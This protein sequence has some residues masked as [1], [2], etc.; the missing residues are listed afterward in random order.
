MQ[1]KYFSEIFKSVET[2]F[3]CTNKMQNATYGWFSTGGVCILGGGGHMHF[4]F[5]AFK[6]VTFQTVQKDTRC[7]P[8]ALLPGP[9]PIPRG[10][11][12]VPQHL[13]TDEGDEGT[14]VNNEKGIFLS[15]GIIFVVQSLSHVLRPLG[16]GGSTPGLA[17]LSFTISQRLLKLK[18]I[19]SVMLSNHV[20]LGCP[21]LIL[22]SIF[23]SIRVFSKELALCIR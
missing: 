10:V 2:T 12:W 9:S 5:A 18:S 11:H 14:Q 3:S 6:R 17:S 16:L 19:E 20:I 23:L 8:P 21:L 1:L 7:L 4:V 15:G 13:N 22:P